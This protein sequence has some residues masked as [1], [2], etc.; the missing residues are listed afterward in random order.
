MKRLIFNKKWL[1]LI[2]ILIVIITISVV[3]SG[4][5]ADFRDVLKYKIPNLDKVGHFIGMGILAFVINNLFHERSSSRITP[6]SLAGVFFAI[7]A[8]TAE[9]YSQKFLTYRS[10][11]YG[12]LA[13]D[14]LGILVF[15]VAFVLMVSK[16]QNNFIT[17]KTN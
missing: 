11:S 5:T 12:D 6:A 8:S 9:E 16:S 4:L 7:P 2:Y 3:N 14:Y 1:A 13:A 17:Q 10:F 15:T